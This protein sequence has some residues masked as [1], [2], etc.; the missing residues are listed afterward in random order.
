MA[1]AVFE[2]D[3]TGYFFIYRKHVA[4]A[5][6]YYLQN[7]IGKDFIN[8]Q[9]SNGLY[10]IQELYK[11]AQNGGGFVEYIWPKNQRYTSR[12]TQSFLCYKNSW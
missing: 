3:Q 5:Y 9:D 6:L 11:A 8:H 7:N 10:L 1:H 2:D 12:N 4:V